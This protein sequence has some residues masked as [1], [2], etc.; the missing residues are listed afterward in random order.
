MLRKKEVQKLIKTP[1]FQNIVEA[2]GKYFKR[3]KTLDSQRLAKML[4]AELKEAFDKLYLLEIAD[5]IESEE[6]FRKELL[7]TKRDLRRLNLREAL[8]EIG[9]Q[10]GELEK[11]EKPTKREKEKLKKLHEQFRDLS[12]ELSELET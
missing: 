7:R 12:V 4:P 10:I 6:K 1:R 5:L 3:Y 9:N 2:L 11:V 8:K